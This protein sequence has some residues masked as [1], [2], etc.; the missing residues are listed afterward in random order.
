MKV[1][2]HLSWN[3][4]VQKP[5]ETPPPPSP[6]PGFWTLPYSITVIIFFSAAVDIHLFRVLS[7]QEANTPVSGC[8][9]SRIPRNDC[10][11][12]EGSRTMTASSYKALPWIIKIKD[13]R[14][15]Q[16]SPT[17]QEFALADPQ[18]SG[19]L[20]SSDPFSGVDQ[21][22]TRLLAACPVKTSSPGFLN[23]LL[24]SQD[25][26][27][28]TRSDRYKVSVINNCSK[29]QKEWRRVESIIWRFRNP[30]PQPL[31]PNAEA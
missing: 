9:F 6:H 10:S 17:G 30:Q 7:V 18:E 8:K 2:L 31:S 14:K 11:K 23:H 3:K 25:A 28:S 26:G 19:H 16:H 21:P 1:T 4:R 29:N 13:C 27:D 15:E 24:K 5:L 20:S 22:A 12:R